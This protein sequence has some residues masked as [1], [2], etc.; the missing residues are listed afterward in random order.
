MPSLEP[1]SPRPFEKHG[2]S[3]PLSLGTQVHIMA[4]A[5]LS[6]WHTTDIVA[7]IDFDEYLYVRDR[8]DFGQVGGAATVFACRRV[9]GRARAVL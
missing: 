2:F 9:P 4:H 1:S 8:M 5:L 6:L 7:F 3:R